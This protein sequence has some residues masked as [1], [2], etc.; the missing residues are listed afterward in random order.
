MRILFFTHEFTRSGAPIILKRLIETLSLRS[1]SARL[2]VAGFG[3]GPLWEDYCSLGI[4][5]RSLEL[6]RSQPYHYREFLELLDDRQPDLLLLNGATL[7]QEAM[8]AHWKGHRVVWWIHEGIHVGQ[9]NGF[10]FSHPELEPFLRQSFEYGQRFVFSA[11]DTRDQ[12]LEFC[13]SLAKR[14]TVIGYGIDL[15][16]IAREREELAPR[17]EAIRAELGLPPDAFVLACVGAIQERKNQAKLVEAFQKLLRARPRSERSGAHLLLIGGVNPTDPDAQRYQRR[18]QASLDPDLAEQVH[19]L[20]LQPSA[21][22]FFVAADCHVLVSTNECSPIANLEAMAF[23]CLC[24]SSRVHGI[25]EVVSDGERGFL[26]DPTDV[27]DIA[28]RLGEVWQTHVTSPGELDASRRRAREFVEQEHELGVMADRFETLI[29]DT[30]RRVPLET[31]DVPRRP[32]VNRLLQE[33]LVLRWC[34]VKHD[35]SLETR[36]LRHR[37]QHLAPG[38]SVAAG[39][40][41]GWRAAAKR[42]LRRLGLVGVLRRLGWVR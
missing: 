4:P 23:G 7:Y 20:G 27:E 5:T 8:L 40:P 14:S 13:P 41:R 18:I 10:P 15:K 6:D 22:P 17:R 34:M 36:L 12:Y 30:I 42:G 31:R 21:A 19:F 26:V 37:A 24:V 1:H 16:A 11:R 33:E 35:A 9:R 38:I 3:T 32:E 28:R 39:P 2:E 25:P 29:E